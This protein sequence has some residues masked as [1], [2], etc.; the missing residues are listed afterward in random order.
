MENV[1]SD[2]RLQRKDTTEP[3]DILLKRMPKTVADGGRKEGRFLKKFYAWQLKHTAKG[4]INYYIHAGLAVG[5]DKAV[6]VQGDLG[7]GQAYPSIY[8]I[9][10]G[11]IMFPQTYYEVWRMPRMPIL[12]HLVA[13]EAKEFVKKAAKANPKTGMGYGLLS[14]LRS[15]DIG[16]FRS[17]LKQDAPADKNKSLW[18]HAVGSKGKF[19]CSEFVVWMYF[20]V[21][22][23]IG[24][25]PP[26]QFIGIN[27]SAANPNALGDALIKSDDWWCLGYIDMS[28]GGTP[29]APRPVVYEGTDNIRDF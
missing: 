15:T 16:I 5:D 29:R 12:A 22:A 6:E 21:A 3:G 17:H 20:Q 25:S 27:S 9:D 7:P 10:L 14:A 23:R 2:V 4:D 11:N 8:E 28:L 18:D 1:K 24:Y 13:K 19:F 26:N